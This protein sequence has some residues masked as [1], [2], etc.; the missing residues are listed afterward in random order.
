LKDF[1]NMSP[2][3]LYIPIHLLENLILNYT[4]SAICS[5]RD[6]LFPK[7]QN[8]KPKEC[9]ILQTIDQER[10]APPISLRYS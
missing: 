8:S 10:A 7:Y 3:I 4:H 5:Q 9:K 1:S 6:L 2:N